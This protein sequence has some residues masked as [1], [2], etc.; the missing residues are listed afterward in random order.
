[1]NTGFVLLFRCIALYGECKE[2]AA[3]AVAGCHVH[4]CCRREQQLFFAADR[5]CDFSERFTRLHAGAAECDRGYDIW[6]SS[7]K[8]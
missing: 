5:C 7:G 4:Y 2:A 1:V 3:A 8:R 6:D